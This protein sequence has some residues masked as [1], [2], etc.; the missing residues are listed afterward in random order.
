MR[1]IDGIQIACAAGLVVFIGAALVVLV[2]IA[3]LMLLVYAVTPRADALT[4][5]LAAGRAS[6]GETSPRCRP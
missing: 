3:V 6:A 2:R 4:G 1:Q 5:L